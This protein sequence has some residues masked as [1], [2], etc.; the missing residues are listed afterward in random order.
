MTWHAQPQT[1]AEWSTHW[2]YQV[3]QHAN[4]C[5]WTPDS[6][7]HAEGIRAAAW[8]LSDYRVSSVSG[9]SIWFTKR[10]PTL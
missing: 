8:R 1:L 9:G 3:L 2:P 5:M 6:T 4:G 10:E 7:N